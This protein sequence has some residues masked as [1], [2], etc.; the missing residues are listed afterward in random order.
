MLYFSVLKNHYNPTTFMLQ[1]KQAIRFKCILF[2]HQLQF[3]NTTPSLSMQE[4]SPHIYCIIL[5]NDVFE[6][7]LS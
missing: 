2:L 7:T 4:I 6:E 5:R 1:I 3:H